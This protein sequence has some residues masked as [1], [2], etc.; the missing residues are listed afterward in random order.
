V[1]VFIW[2]GLPPGAS[3]AVVYAS[4]ITPPTPPTVHPEIE[5]FADTH[6]HQFA[7]LAFGG[8]EVWGSPVD[9]FDIDGSQFLADPDAA[10]KRALPNSD[11]IYVSAAQAADYL[12]LTDLPATFTPAATKCEVGLC[13]AAVPP[14]PCPAGTGVPGNPCWRIEIHGSNGQGDLLNRM[15]AQ[16]PEHG[17]AGFPLMQGWPAF[18]VVTAQQVYWE[19]LKRAHDHGLKLMTMLAVNNQV[20]CHLAVHRLS[21]GCDDDSSVKRQ[22]EG[23]IALEKYID[24]VEG[25]D[26]FYKIVKT[27]AEARDAINK[28]KL[29][30]VL[31]AEV[32]TPWRC[33]RD[34]NCDDDGVK[35]EVQ[36]YY[37]MGIR[38]VYP[39][40][41]M[42][43]QFGGAAL[44]DGLFEVANALVNGGQ[45]FD[46]V[47]GAQCP[48]GLEWRSDIRE[49]IGSVQGGIKTAFDVVMGVSVAALAGEPTA[50]LLVGT[51]TATMGVLVGTLTAAVPLFSMYAPMAYTYLSTINPDFATFAHIALLIGGPFLPVLATAGLVLLVVAAPGEVGTAP[52]ANCNGR[53]LTDLGATLVNELMDHQMMVDV[54]HSDAATLEDILKI[55]EDRKYPGI[56]SGHTGLLGAASTHAEA[57]PF[58]PPGQPWDAGKT[59]RHEGVKSDDTIR[60]I[61]ALGGSVSLALAQGG[62]ARIR[63]FDPNDNVPFDCGGS[64]QTFAQVYLYATKGL[65]LKAVSFGSDMNGFS[66]WPVPRYGARF[67]G[68]KPGQLGDIGPGYNPEAGKLTYPFLD[69]LTPAGSVDKYQ[70]GTRVWDYNFDGL[71]H[72]GLYP[73]FIADLE[74]IGLTKAELAP[75]FAGVE[76]YVRMWEKIDDAA[77]PTV[78][79]GTVGEDWHDSDVSVPCIAF[80]SGFGLDDDGD[81]SF[82]L[83]TSVPLG[84]E[85]DDA[86]TDTHGP[87]CDA[88]VHCTGKVPAISG[89]NVDKKDPTVVVAMPAAGTPSYTVG[90]IVMADYSCTDFGSGVAT[91]AGP[92][93]TGGNLDTSAGAHPFTVSATDKVGHAVSV[94]HPYVVGYA[95]CPLYDPT[96]T[97]KAGSTVPIK[98]RVCDATGANLSSPSIVL[99]ATGVTR[100]SN[101]TPAA[102]EDSGNA[103]PDFDFRY[104]AGLGGYIFNLSTNGF[105][106][107][108]YLLNYSVSGDPTGHTAAFAVR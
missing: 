71:A 67:C 68:N 89:I 9:P 99:H 29:A 27:A 63:D 76:A 11:Y 100:T 38:V 10:R 97:K 77:A 13:F 14:S 98:V 103:N 82:F 40:H 8:L 102:L 72:I 61:V 86:S 74:K 75:L 48:A 95:I 65:E 46:I 6:V 43:N 28:G 53:G 21:F 31:G 79:C 81:A 1:A 35:A 92:V 44:Y 87:I 56:V 4:D 69:N 12:G 16:L 50:L 94:A 24:M 32:D 19:W 30:V 15:I 3:R 78:R 22:I 7:N 57:K 73:D 39:V 84:T 47:A 66:T 64:S 5:G 23:A 51:L 104:D 52:Q 90:Q 105:A 85:T 41:I 17:T 42:D 106:P 60:R 33:R 62:R 54:D 80:D 55:A 101:N 91:C 107:G 108:S 26:G 58:L 49:T 93:P 45:F 20:L 83:S 88:A 70:F 96:V 2:L 36:K 18:D 25:G 37:D 34:G 59:G